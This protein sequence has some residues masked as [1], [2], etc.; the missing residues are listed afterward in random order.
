MADVR[1]HHP[2]RLATPCAGETL[3]GMCDRE[4]FA[5]T[6]A[7]LD[8]LRVLDGN[9]DPRDDGYAAVAAHAQVHATLALAWA[10][11]LGAS[12]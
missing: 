8:H 12:R 4:M 10:T 3:A 6:E 11:R 7:A 5:H 9:V 1:L 2:H